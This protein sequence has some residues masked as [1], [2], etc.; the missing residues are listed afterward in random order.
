MGRV[1]EGGKERTKREELRRREEQFAEEV[2]MLCFAAA[3]HQCLHQRPDQ[4]PLFNW[5]SLHSADREG[6]GG[7]DA[8][9]KRENRDEGVNSPP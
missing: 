7:E 8:E 5:H 1:I 6:E 3:C 4:H 9:K 2:V